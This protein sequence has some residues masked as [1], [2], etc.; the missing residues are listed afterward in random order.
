MTSLWRN[1]WFLGNSE[2]GE[3]WLK[4]CDPCGA[5][6]FTYLFK[7][8]CASISCLPCRRKMM[9][10]FFSGLICLNLSTVVTIGR[11]NDVWLKVTW[12]F[13]PPLPWLRSFSDAASLIFS[14]YLKKQDKKNTTHKV[15]VMGKF[16]NVLHVSV[17]LKSL[18]W[19]LK[20]TNSV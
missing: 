10:G 2:K 7:T 15:L 9:G 8:G 19:I 16:A 11:G 6:L 1:S 4:D 12:P 14:R 20:K 5:V 18:F 13:F 17:N 3:N